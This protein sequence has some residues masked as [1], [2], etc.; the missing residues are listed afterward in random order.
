MLFVVN[1]N[2][3]GMFTQNQMELL[4][5]ICVVMVTHMMESVTIEEI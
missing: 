4:V 1:M 2:I 5:D 3:V